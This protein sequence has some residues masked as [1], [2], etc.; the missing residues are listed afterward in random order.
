MET[1]EMSTE[2]NHDMFNGLNILAICC[3]FVVLPWFL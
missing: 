1:M 2:T 3:Y